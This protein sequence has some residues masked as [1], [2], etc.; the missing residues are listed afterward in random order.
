M[1][2]PRV[3]PIPPQG[4]SFLFWAPTRQIFS[5]FRPGRWRA[6]RIHAHLLDK[7]RRSA[8]IQMNPCRSPKKCPSGV[9][10]WARPVEG[11]IPPQGNSFL[12]W[13]PTRQMC[14]FWVPTGIVDSGELDVGR[15]IFRHEAICFFFGHPRGKSVL[16]LATPKNGHLGARGS[17][18]FCISPVM[19]VFP[20][21]F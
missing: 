4:N 1:A 2:K 5:F 6:Q 3:G 13:V 11:P 19:C 8:W 17:G 16:F 21:L 18:T 10:F 9:C 7:S 12:F 15:T 20:H 14:S